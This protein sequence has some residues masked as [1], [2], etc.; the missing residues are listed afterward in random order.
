MH[1]IF[2]LGIKCAQR[3]QRYQCTRTDPTTMQYKFEE[4]FLKTYQELVGNGIDTIHIQEL[5]LR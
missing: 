1:A 2:V 3:H 4:A 5:A